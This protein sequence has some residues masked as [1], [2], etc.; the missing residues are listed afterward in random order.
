ML[1]AAISN[2]K[3]ICTYVY[4]YVYVC[5]CVC[6][7]TCVC[8]CVCVRTLVENQTEIVFRKYKTYPHQY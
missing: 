4:N 7:F 2:E 1:Q 3:G 6:A 5:T 8:V